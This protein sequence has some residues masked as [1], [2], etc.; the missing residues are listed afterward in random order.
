ML[1]MFLRYGE[2]SVIIPTENVLTTV[3]NYKKQN[4]DIIG[5]YFERL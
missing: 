4:V 1:K 3:E 5:Y 2:I